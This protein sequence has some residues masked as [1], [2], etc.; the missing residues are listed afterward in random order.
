MSATVQADPA[1]PA[2]PATGQFT[3]RALGDRT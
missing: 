3:H 2:G 1:T